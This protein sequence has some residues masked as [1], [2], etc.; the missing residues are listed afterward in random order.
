M[1]N[2]VFQISRTENK[3]R[4]IKKRNYPKKNTQQNEWEIGNRRFEKDTFLDE[5]L[6]LERLDLPSDWLGEK[7]RGV[8]GLEGSTFAWGSSSSQ[9]GPTQETGRWGDD[10]EGTEGGYKSGSMADLLF[11]TPQ[12]T[13][14]RLRFSD[15]K[16]IRGMSNRILETSNSSSSNKLTRESQ[17]LQ[18][19]L[20]IGKFM[21]LKSTRNDGVWTEEVKKGNGW[22]RER[23]RAGARDRQRKEEAGGEMECNLS[24]KDYVSFK[25]R[26]NSWKKV[27]ISI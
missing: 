2:V 6:F 4:K 8:A 10:D 7:E 23:E 24:F 17:G 11:L 16:I 26:R 25:T 5:T 19:F 18:L 9:V 13:K 15:W 21:R 3:N 27:I 20:F 1:G 14:R 12:A 22:E